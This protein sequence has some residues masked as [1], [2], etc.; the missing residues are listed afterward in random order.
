MARMLGRTLRRISWHKGDGDWPAG[1][2]RKLY[3]RSQRR[4][5]GN[6]WRRYWQS[7]LSWA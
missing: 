4:R 3:I 7:L 6:L 1:R 5:E 2:D